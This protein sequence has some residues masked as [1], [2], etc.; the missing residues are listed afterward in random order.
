MT[1]WSRADATKQVF[2]RGACAA[3]ASPTGLMDQG[4]SVEPTISPGKPTSLLS[5]AFALVIR[6]NDT[7]RFL[8]ARLTRAAL[9]QHDKAR[10]KGRMKPR[11]KDTGPHR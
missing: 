8:R 3:R 5:T 6:C 10:A 1:R 4:C 9:Q 7:A 2:V 11:E